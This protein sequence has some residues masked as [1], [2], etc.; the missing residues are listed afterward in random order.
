VIHLIPVEHTHAAWHLV[1]G[2]LEKSVA[3]SNGDVSLDE[4]KLKLLDG[5][6]LLYLVT[7][8]CE[9]VL[10]CYVVSI[11]NRIN[12]RVAYIV[13]IAGAIVKKDLFVQMIGCLK[14]QDITAIEGDVRTSV[15]R[16][17]NRLGFINKSV[18]TY[19]KI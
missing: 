9:D 14:E 8:D 2:H 11:Y 12:D 18:K 13:A 10:G 7:D 16:L 19:F 15:A 6:W 4:I 1:E 5:T 3:Q 17:L